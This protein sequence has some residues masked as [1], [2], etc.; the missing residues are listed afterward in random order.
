MSWP[1]RTPWPIA[2]RAREIADHADHADYADHAGRDGRD[3]DMRDAAGRGTLSAEPDHGDRRDG[4]SELAM[5]VGAGARAQRIACDGG[6]PA[7]G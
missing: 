4:M 3:G 6:V 2:E 7:M 5:I 1:T